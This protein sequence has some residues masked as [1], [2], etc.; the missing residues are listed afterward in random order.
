MFRWLLTY[1]LAL[2]VAGVA[3]TAELRR[4]V[5]IILADDLG[6]GDLGCFGNTKYKTPNLDA[7]AKSGA[8]LTSFYTPVPFC[9]P[10]RAALLTGRYPPRCG[11][12][13]NPVPKED[14][15]G[16]KNADELGLPVTEVTLANVFHEGG[17]ATGCF[18]KWHL[19]HQPQ[20]RPLKRGFDDYLG[21]LYSN[22]MHPVE[23]IDG[24]KKAEYPIDQNTLTRKLTD[25]A[26]KFIESNRD[27]PFFLYVP[28]A[29][30]HKPLA[31]SEPFRG[32]SGGG[33]YGDAVQELDAGVGEIL[34]K[35]KEYKLE[36]RTLVVFAS[37]N[38]PWYGGSAGGLRGMKGTSWEGGFRVP[39]IARLPNVIPA[40]RTSDE[41]VI[42]ADLFATAIAFAGLK[43]PADRAIDGKDLLPLMTGKTDTGPHEYVFSTRGD[44][45]ATV[46]SGKWKLHVL[47]PGGKQRNWK[48][49]DPYTDPRGPDGT[50]II[51][52]KEQAHPSQNPGVLTGVEGKAGMLFDLIADRSEQTDVAAANP[53]IV[54]RLTEAAQEFESGLKR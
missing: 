23:L 19:G 52:P 42:M 24:D 48:P 49:D 41:P 53:E 28:H 38:G 29:M 25:R 31:A 44:R 40:G 26:L 50:R 4:N 9:A 30:P 34:S 22:D 36:D 2:A 43:P 18:G 39:L 7:M 33:L 21:V 8:K 37:D 54:K 17:Y 5:V 10:T 51:A 14:L 6:Y 1:C 46:R 11:L 47:A 16:A 15:G 3:F 13:G 27:K 20:F 32:K 35:L 45:V 12:T